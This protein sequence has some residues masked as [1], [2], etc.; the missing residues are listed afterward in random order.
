MHILRLLCLKQD[1]EV[2]VSQEEHPPD[3]FFF[4]LLIVPALIKS[5]DFHTTMIVLL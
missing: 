3:F 1:K 5:V 4:F 2:F